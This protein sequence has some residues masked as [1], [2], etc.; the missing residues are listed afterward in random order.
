[1][2]DEN[3]KVE[4]IGEEEKRALFGSYRCLV[5]MSERLFRLVALQIYCFYS[6]AACY[7]L[8]SAHCSRPILWD[9]NHTLKKS[10]KANERR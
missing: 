3:P 2:V 1:M 9:E 6:H 7:G 10:M 5:H 4:L 8:S